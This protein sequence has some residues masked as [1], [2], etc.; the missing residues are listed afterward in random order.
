MYFKTGAKFPKL[1]SMAAQM[2]QNSVFQL[3][4]IQSTFICIKSMF[5]FIQL[6]FYLMMAQIFLVYNV[7]ND[8]CT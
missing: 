4:F 1:N 7:R 5:I 2:V 8:V 6:T 3:T